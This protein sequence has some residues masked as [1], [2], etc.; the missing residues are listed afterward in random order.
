VQADRLAGNFPDLVH[1]AGQE[2]DLVMPVSNVA[3]QLQDADT[4]AVSAGLRILLQIGL[5]LQGL[6]NPVG[7]SRGQAGDLGHL[8]RGH[9]R[10][11]SAKGLQDGKSAQDRLRPARRLGGCDGETPNSNEY[12]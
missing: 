11:V 12:Q 8:C 5:A 2:R 9:L 10:S 6:E 7:G 3:G 1:R 4:E